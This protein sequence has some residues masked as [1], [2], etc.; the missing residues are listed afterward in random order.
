MTTLR[1]K[2]SAL[3]AFALVGAL[4]SAVPA[5]AHAATTPSP[6]P[7]AS[8]ADGPIDCPAAFPIASAVDGVK[9]IGWTVSKGTTPERFDATV[10]GVMKDGIGPGFDVILAEVSSPALTRAGGVWAG[11]SGSPVYSS[12]GRLIGA[13]AYTFTFGSSMIAGLTPGETMLP[14]TG[15]S[16]APKAKAAV[17]PK[18]VIKFDAAATQRLAR[19]GVSPAAASGGLRRLDMPM[20]VPGTQNRFTQHFVDD[21]KKQGID[22]RTG[23]GTSSASGVSSEIHAGGNFGAAV[24]TGAVTLAG[25]GTT[26]AVCNGRAVAFGHPFLGQGPVNFAATSADAVTVMP[27]ALG[28]AFKAANVGSVVGTLD[29]DSYT[30]IAAQLGT[31]PSTNIPIV[32]TITDASGKNVKS[33]STA[34]DTSFAGRVLGFQ[35]YYGLA[36]AMG[37]DQVPGSAAVNLAITGKRADGRTFTFTRGDKLSAAPGGW[38][39]GEPVA[40]SLWDTVSLFTSQGLEDITITKI[41]ATVKVSPTPVGYSFA[42]ISYQKGA[43]WTRL[44][45]SR[46]TKVKPGPLALRIGL[47]PVKG[48]TSTAT[49]VDTAITVPETFAGDLADLTVTGGA[50]SLYDVDLSS[51]KTFDELLKLLSKLP[52]SNSIKVTLTPMGS[53]KPVSTTVT[54]PAPIDQFFFYSSLDVAGSA[55]TPT[56]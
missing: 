9:G 32:T 15:S 4:A 43:T 6:K 47:T 50:T 10:L 31:M 46:T 8:P 34:H 27:D 42:G 38:G 29:R 28:S 40:N 37:G 19:A 3:A 24:S 21:L 41:T 52:K 51:A 2:T 33:T 14:L 54:L 45:D 56:K 39:L 11:M 36:K 5:T 18:A 30:G 16:V 26:T 55:E 7:S 20:W 22:A 17:S 35:T 48:S 53:G 25:I 1:A 44:V 12:D 13:V 23:S 49:T